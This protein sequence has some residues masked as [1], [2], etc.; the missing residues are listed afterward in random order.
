MPGLRFTRVLFPPVLNVPMLDSNPSSTEKTTDM[1]K[2]KIQQT[3]LSTDPARRKRCGKHRARQRVGKGK[4]IWRRTCFKCLTMTWW[5]ARNAIHTS[6]LTVS[7]DLTSGMVLLEWAKIGARAMIYL[8]FHTVR[9]CE[10]TGLTF[11]LPLERSWRWQKLTVP[12]QI[13]PTR[14]FQTMLHAPIPL[15]DHRCRTGTREPWRANRPVLAHF[16]WM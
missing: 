15:I 9:G 3:S 7:S 8:I 14:T 5:L 4:K 6:S 13:L 2:L 10:L 12:H 16:I 11:N 1:A